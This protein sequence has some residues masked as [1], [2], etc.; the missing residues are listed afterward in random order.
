[1]K[2]TRNPHWRERWSVFALIYALI[3]FASLK[4]LT[5]KAL[6]SDILAM[7]LITVFSSALVYLLVGRIVVW[8]WLLAKQ[9]GAGFVAG[10]QEAAANRAKMQEIAA[11]L[12]LEPTPVEQR[13]TS[14]SKPFAFQPVEDHAQSNRILN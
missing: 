12:A 13:L 4:A 10:N 2:K 6:T 14:I 8:F 7:M 3:W 11:K 5:G 1:M 9:V